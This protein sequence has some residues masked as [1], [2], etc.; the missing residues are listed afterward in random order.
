M[1]FVFLCPQYL[2]SESNCSPNALEPKHIYSLIIGKSCTNDLDAE[3]ACDLLGI[4]ATNYN[5]LALILMESI[6]FKAVYLMKVNEMG[7]ET[8]EHTKIKI[9]NVAIEFLIGIAQ[10]NDCGGEIEKC[11]DKFRKAM[12]QI[13]E[14]IR[15]EI[16]NHCI[17]DEAISKFS[18]IRNLH[19]EVLG[20]EGDAVIKIKEEV[21]K[22]AI[23]L[24]EN[25]DIIK[26]QQVLIKMILHAA[27][28]ALQDLMYDNKEAN[29]T[30]VLKTLERKM[31]KIS[32][33]VGVLVLA[34]SKASD[35]V[36]YRKTN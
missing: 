22:L 2:I 23:S 4:Q 18:L 26:D 31:N 11:K 16:I 29:R 32:N 7:L 33:Q 1:Y 24:W 3:S 25:R 15:R 5:Q 28:I 14:S 10:D 9:N 21:N 34:G 12:E 13:I 27:R 36:T 30:F 19:F 17:G 20:R 8:K 6:I 35:R